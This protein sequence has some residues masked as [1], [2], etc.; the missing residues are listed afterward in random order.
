MDFIAKIAVYAASALALVWINLWFVKFAYQGFV[1][2]D[3]RDRTGADQRCRGE[4][5]TDDHISRM[6][7]AQ[8]ASIQAELDQSLAELKRRRPPAGPN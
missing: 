2:G 8:I 5:V 6:I 3:V 1:G 7:V 4:T